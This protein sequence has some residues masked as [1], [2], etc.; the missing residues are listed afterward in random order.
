MVNFKNHIYSSNNILKYSFIQ[1][2][3]GS[4]HDKESHYA[5][6]RWGFIERWDDENN[7]IENPL[8]T[9]GITIENMNKARMPYALT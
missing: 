2:L 1:S 9:K 3:F 8:I 5:E 7:F 4:M 6:R